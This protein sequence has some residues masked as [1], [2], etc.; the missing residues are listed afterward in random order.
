MLPRSP[1][2]E[3]GYDQIGDLIAVK[4]ANGDGIGRYTDWVKPIL[5]KRPIAGSEQHGDPVEAQ[6]RDIREWGHR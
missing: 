5:D 3:I 1:C 4:I 6:Y 2:I